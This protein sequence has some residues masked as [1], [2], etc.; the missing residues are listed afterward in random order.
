VKVVDALAGVV[1]LGID[2]AP[3]I[4]FIEWHPTYVDTVRSAIT[5]IS[6]NVVQG[7]TSVLTSLSCLHS[8]SAPAIS[9]LRHTI[10]V[11]FCGEAET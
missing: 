3:F 9:S 11:R 4:Y 10:V 1:R 7:Y 2:T 8:L 5:L 6:R